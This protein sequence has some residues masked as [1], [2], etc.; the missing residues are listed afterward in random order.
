ML[1]LKPDGE[2]AESFKFQLN[3]I[4]DQLDD[5]KDN[6]ISK[7]EFIEGCLKDEFLLSFLTTTGMENVK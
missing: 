3:N 4:W 7:I 5:N 1:N 2:N 6:R